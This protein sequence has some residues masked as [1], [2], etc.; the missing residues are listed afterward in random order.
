M[1][2]SALLR[3]ASRRRFA[4]ALS[5]AVAIEGGLALG[6]VM[7]G[8]R[9]A[10]SLGRYDEPI[11]VDLASLAGPSP[12]G[13]SMPAVRPQHAQI[14]DSGPQRGEDP[15]V[16]SQ[17]REHTAAPALL[18][19]PMSAIT[20]Q[21]QV[22]KTNDSAAIVESDSAAPSPIPNTAPPESNSTALGET[23]TPAASIPALAPA[24]S[25]R[26]TSAFAGTDATSRVTAEIAS[27][28]ATHKTYPEAARRRGAQGNVRFK[29]EIGEE[30]ALKSILLDVGSGS[31]LLDSAAE[32][33]L[34]SA[35]PLVDPPGVPVVVD[36]AVRYS[37]TD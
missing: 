21:G 22:S 26:P 13:T 11:F 23:S 16:P 31:R 36:I 24:S 32:S 18:S 27:F 30:G 34:R 4:L 6:L 19:S 25:G 37:L 5:M 28:V 2:R 33:L 17:P 3:R 15:S 20:P 8:S 14:D 1:D 10:S 9:S 29:L 7:A 35:F 12:N